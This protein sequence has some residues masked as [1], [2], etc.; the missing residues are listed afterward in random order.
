M[1]CAFVYLIAG[2]MINFRSLQTLTS[3]RTRL[4]ENPGLFVV[5]GDAQRAPGAFESA[6]AP[7]ALPRIAA[8]PTCGGGT[9]REAKS[10]GFSDLGMLIVSAEIACVLGGARCYTDHLANPH[11]PVA[12]EVMDD[13]EAIVYP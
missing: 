5:G 4:G 12:A 7:Q 8:A 10:K 11:R 3:A 9:C 6:G 2:C 13:W 1:T